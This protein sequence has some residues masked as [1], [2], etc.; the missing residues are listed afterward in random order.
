LRSEPFKEQ[1]KHGRWEAFRKIVKRVHEDPPCNPRD[2]YNDPEI[3]VPKRTV[4]H[5]L[6]L[7]V[8]IGIFKQLD[9]GR[10]AWIDYDVPSETT[11]FWQPQPEEVKQCIEALEAKDTE[12]THK[13]F[14]SELRSILNSGYWDNQLEAFLIKILDNPEAH[15]EEIDRLLRAEPRNRERIEL[16]F[17]SNRDKIY[18]LVKSSDALSSTALSIFV[19]ISDSKEDLKM[20]EEALEGEGAE[21]VLM[22]AQGYGWKLY[23][24][25][26]LDFKKFLQKALRHESEI[27]RQCALNLMSEIQHI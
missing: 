24:K 11:T 3:G 2:I 10:Y 1:H 27:V 4:T 6:K 14:L 23:K 16:F 5:N 19:D 22:A 20:I 13:A 8:F 12:E 17:K 26:N 18:D 21:R 15:E 9:D 7:G 25:F